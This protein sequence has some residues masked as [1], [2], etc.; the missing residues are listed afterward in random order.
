VGGG[1]AGNNAAIAAVEKGV[2]VLVA[3]KGA[4]ARCGAI[5][6]GVDHFMAYL[7][8]ND[9]WDTRKAY[10]DMVA[11][12]GRGA[13]NLSVQNAV[14]CNELSATLARMEKINSLKQPDGT[15]YR[16]KSFGMPGPYFINFNEPTGFLV[17]H[18]LQIL[19]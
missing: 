8:T 11:R 14:F 3:D 12:I 9:E 16:T 1:L 19:T 13:V 17:V 10:L 18:F 6:G 15:Y 5:A 4:I 7:E 2:S